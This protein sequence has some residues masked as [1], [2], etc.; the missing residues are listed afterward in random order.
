M[1]HSLP[2]YDIKGSMAQG[3]KAVIER[4]I[5]HDML[6]AELEDNPARKCP[7]SKI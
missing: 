1:A 2:P 7:Q 4:R 5:A 3:D 6:L